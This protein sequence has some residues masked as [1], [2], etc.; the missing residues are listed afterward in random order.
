VAVDT[1]VSCPRTDEDT[2]STESNKKSRTTPTGSADQAAAAE[3][4]RRTQ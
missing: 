4:P 1:A 2:L 3:Q